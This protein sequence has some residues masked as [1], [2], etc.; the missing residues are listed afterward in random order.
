MELNGKRLLVCDCE[1]TMTI[2]GKVLAK[3]CQAAA[4]AGGMAA[5]AG[6][7]AT[8]GAQ[9]LAVNTHMCRAQLDEF[10]RIAGKAG[11]GGLLVACTQEAPL[12][13]ETLDG[14][15]DKAPNARFTNIRERA[16]WSKAAT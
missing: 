8:E 10:E 2:D 15:G 4:R 12:F 1:G 11:K 3:A 13:L 9:E 6:D 16:G 7:E 14:M 5:P